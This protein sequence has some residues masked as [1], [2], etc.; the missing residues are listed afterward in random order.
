MENK[1][2]F[3]YDLYIGTNNGQEEYLRKPSWDCG[4]YW[5]FGYL[6][7]IKIHHHCDT[8]SKTKNMFEALKEYYNEDIKL[9]DD[10]LWTFC[11]LMNSFYILKKT[12]ELYYSG[13]SGYTQNPISI[14]LKNEKEYK[15]INNELMPKIFDQIALLLKK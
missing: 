2:I 12:S 5:G 8:V 6:G 7:N 11:E 9:S 3:T 4:W 14:Q 13:C 1:T 15:R 10:D